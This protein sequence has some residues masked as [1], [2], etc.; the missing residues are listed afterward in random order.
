[1]C[2]AEL[3]EIEKGHPSKNAQIRLSLAQTCPELSDRS[4]CNNYDPTTML[5][6]MELRYL[7]GSTFLAPRCTIRANAQFEFLP[8]VRAIW[9]AAPNL[10]FCPKFRRAS[11]DK[12]LGH[13]KKDKCERCLAV[14]RQLDKESSLIVYLM[15]GRN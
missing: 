9:H 14:Y 6:G 1:M 11:A 3:A 13:I 5:C 12:V 4:D 2:A 10:T 7:F 8:E 15:S